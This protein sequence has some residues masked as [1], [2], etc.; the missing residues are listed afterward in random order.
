M[1]VFIFI[2]TTSD[3]SQFGKKLQRDPHKRPSAKE[4]LKHPFLSKVDKETVNLYKQNVLP[5][6]NKSS[7]KV[8]QTDI[9]LCTETETNTNLK[10]VFNQPRNEI[11]T[12]SPKNV[13]DNMKNVLCPGL[14]GET[15]IVPNRFL[16]KI[17]I[18]R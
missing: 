3:V 1:H 2:K 5:I 7:N 12:V 15:S 13:N 18:F 17:D 4:L 11:R 16:V 9:N 6:F 8:P 14:N 10:T